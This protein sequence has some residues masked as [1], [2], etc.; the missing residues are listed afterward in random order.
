MKHAQFAN[1][2]SALLVWLFVYT[3]LSKL[4][5]YSTFR[6]QLGKSPFVTEYAGL[7]S[8]A[9][10][11]AELVTAA[12][13]ITRRTRLWGLYAAFFLMSTF[14]G[15]IYAMLHYS[16][17]LPCSCGGVIAAMSWQQHLIFNISFTG[18][19]LAAILLEGVSLRKRALQHSSRQ[20]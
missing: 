4:S 11:L 20:G 3:A 10:P 17:Y 1:V 9:I 12:L 6:L 5:S 7:L 19:A 18:L 8:W 13:L 14:T 2:I 16:D 15:Y